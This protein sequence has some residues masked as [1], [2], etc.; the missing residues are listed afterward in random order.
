MADVIAPLCAGLAVRP[1]VRWPSVL[2]PGNDLA[3]ADQLP[4][5]AAL[6]RRYSREPG[7][8][9]RRLSR[10]L[11]MAH[12]REPGPRHVDVDQP[13]TGG[14]VQHIAPIRGHL[15]GEDPHAG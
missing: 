2:E 1:G 13:R 14:G 9:T 5:K 3:V 6:R 8:V 12:V 4:M 10:G 15:P 11:S 7:H